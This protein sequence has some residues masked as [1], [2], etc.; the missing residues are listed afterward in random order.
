MKPEEKKIILRKLMQDRLN[1]EEESA[2]NDTPPVN[3]LMRHQWDE[4]SDALPFDAPDE[5]QIWQK[6]QRRIHENTSERNV[7][8]YRIYS[9]VASVLLILGIGSTVYFLV[10]K[11]EQPPMYVVSS[12]IRNIESV[13]LPDGTEVQMGPGSKLTFPAQFIG[14]NREVQ[15]EGQAFFD[16]ANNRNKPFI[17]HTKDMDVQALGTAFELFSY[18]IENKAEATLL[19]GKIKVS[20]PNP[21]STSG[22][23]KEY[24]LSPNEKILF[25]RRNNSIQISTL[26]ADKYT[27]WREYGV[28]TFENEK[29]SMI[30][31]RLE[32]WY[33]RHLICQKDIAEQFRFT[34]K[35]KDESLERIL[36]M[37]S[38]S[39][40]LRHRETDSGD[41]ILT[42]K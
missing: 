3:G 21:T 36:F 28:L 24:I 41:Y 25:D 16:V 2:L 23:K 8:F 14:K 5:Y 11:K 31:P 4:A 35:V 37:M 33:G 26:N 6:I 1:V 29:L 27:S 42:L 38:K 15:L 7:V 19:H 18:D 34:F 17:V 9:W 22:K 30:I 13:S 20:L 10:S 39:S 40:I 32:Q 12:G